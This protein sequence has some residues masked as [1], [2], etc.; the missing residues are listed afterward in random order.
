MGICSSS[1]TR[2][3][4]LFIDKETY[5]LRTEIYLFNKIVVQISDFSLLKEIPKT[6]FFEEES[7]FFQI[8]N[9]EYDI[10]YRL[11]LEISY[12]NVKPKLRNALKD[13][14]KVLKEKI[15]D[16]KKKDIRII[17]IHYNE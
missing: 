4:D 15:P 16:I 13:A 8:D 1:Y 11:A 9:I 12:I 6:K 7:Q 14:Y 10:K 2:R 5:E 3:K 17:L